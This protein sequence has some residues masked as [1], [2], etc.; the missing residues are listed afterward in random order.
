LNVL[1]KILYAHSKGLS[2]SEFNVVITNILA[3]VCAAITTLLV[4]SSF[5]LFGMNKL[6]PAYALLV[7]LL[8]AVPVLNQRGYDDAGRLLFCLIP[9]WVT[10]LITLWMKHLYP[11]HSY[12]VYFD[13]RY[14]I[15]S[16]TILPVLVF[17]LHEWVKIAVCLLS[18]LICLVFFDPIH[19]AFGLGYYQRGFDAK[20]YFWINYT[21]LACYVG[22]VTAVLIVKW[23]DSKIRMQQQQLLKEKE[24]INA[25]LEQSKEELRRQ[26]LEL[27][28]RNEEIRLQHEELRTSHE[29]LENAHAL[30]RDQSRKLED[31][32]RKLSEML[33]EKSADLLRTNEE[34][35]KSN[36]ELRQFSFTV[37][38]NLRGPVARLLGLTHLIS[39][40]ENPAE[41]VRMSRLVQQSA[42]E[43]DEV[44]KDLSRIIDIR[45]ELYRVREQIFL[46][47]IWNRTLE[48]V[49]LEKDGVLFHTEFESAPYIFGIRPMVQ[50]I[51]YNLLT[52][53]IKY[54]APGRPLCVTIKSY[55]SAAGKVIIEFRDNGMGIDMSRHGHDLFRLYKRFH[56]HVPGKGMGLYL[57]KTQME[58][59]GGTVDA[60]SRPDEGALFRLT[61][62]V[63]ENME[64]Q[65][66]FENEAACLYY[67]AY[68]NNT[69]IIWKRQ[70][71][72]D[73]YREVFSTVLQTIKTYNTPGWIADLRH[74]G[75]V[76]PEDQH[77]FIETVLKTAAAN[78]LK[79]IAAIALH[80]PVRQDYHQRMIEITQ[81]LGVEL[82]TFDNLETAVHWMRQFSGNV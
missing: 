13:S 35:I 24:K 67:D 54:Q 76:S 32:N 43:L 79:R 45:N 69:V 9:S 36:N 53:A 46:Q 55:F 44:L 31:Y 8:L 50:S 60:E 30:I 42:R 71:T 19:N 56:H 20:A 15:L 65:V 66:F 81:A 6:M 48:T 64:R 82:R 18:S 33:A 73:E 59:M 47:H 78:N 38:H 7:L 61:F 41:I 1:R 34:L 57:V 40:E 80:H 37:S 12:L 11:Q 26:A 23:R 5:F 52:N 70:I 74:Q 58:L 49:S 63:P 51:L 25:E 17:G 27:I 75:I 10:L 28:S 2:G 62:P 14:V 3:L 72:S 29:M 21:L 22:L 39:Q 68:I 4:V 77:W 16:S